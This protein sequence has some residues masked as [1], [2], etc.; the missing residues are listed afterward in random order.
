MALNPTNGAALLKTLYPHNK[1]EDLTNQNRP[2]LSML[3]KNSKFVGN[4][5]RV[6]VHTANPQAVSSDF[7]TASSNKGNSAS[8]A[9]TV[10]HHKLYSLGSIDNL[11]IRQSASD[12]G[13]F[14]R[15]LQYEIDGVFNSISDVMEGQLFGAGEGALG[16]ITAASD[17][18]TD[19]ITLVNKSD[20]VYFED[21]MKLEV[22]AN[23]DG[24]SHRTGTVEIQSVDRDAGTVTATAAWDAGIA[25]VAASDYIFI[26][27]TAGDTIC[28]GLQKII[29]I[30]APT[31]GDSLYGLDRSSDPDRL[32]GVRLQSADVSG[33]PV[34]QKLRKLLSK[35]A[36]RGVGAPDCIF[37]NHDR[38]N[39]LDTELGNRVR[40][41]DVQKGNVG[42]RTITVSG[43]EGPVK[44]VAAARCPKDYA[45][46]LRMRDWELMSAG[47]CPGFLDLD[48]K[49]LRESSADAYEVRIGAYFAL[50]CRAPGSQG[51]VDLS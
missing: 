5:A 21:G 7:S 28:P 26:E 17:V 32:A 45:W 13:A 6:A 8:S 9:F 23:A 43:P 20:A 31:S 49:L 29:P 16:Q 48:G 35:V 37:L 38:W 39:E 36:S 42:F 33:L 12:R 34:E 22:S 30:N 46:A 47:A 14:V 40:Y 27:G 3:P 25:A 41:D 19:T 2:L 15:A 44:V 10:V 11:M 50:V 18:T 51:I 1:V 4:Q 24:S